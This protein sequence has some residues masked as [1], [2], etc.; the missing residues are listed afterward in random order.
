MEVE[1]R[2]TDSLTVVGSGF[3]TVV[4]L[5]L[6]AKRARLAAEMARMDVFMVLEGLIVRHGTGC[7]ASIPLKQVLGRGGCNL[8][9]HWW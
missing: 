4:V 2:R 9:I 1:V 3:T 6:E 8:I 7:A 5:Q